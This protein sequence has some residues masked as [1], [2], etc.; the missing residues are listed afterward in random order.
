MS[1]LYHSQM[2][3]QLCSFGF[4]FA[5]GVPF[6]L[7]LQTLLKL[8]LIF[9]FSLRRIE[10]V[11][12]RHKGHF[13]PMNR[14]LVIERNCEFCSVSLHHLGNALRE[15]L[16]NCH[17]F[18]IRLNLRNRESRSRSNRRNRERREIE[19][20][21]HPFFIFNYTY[22][23][24]RDF[25]FVKDFSKLM[26]KISYCNFWHILSAYSLVEKKISFL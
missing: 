24:H 3:I 17:I 16:S 12:F 21:H 14:A 20:S 11:L 23:I 18:Q 15:H 7:T 10:V 19:H 4:G 6:L 9:V 25:S 2:T 8:H 13:N 5:L 1:P 26:T 22:I